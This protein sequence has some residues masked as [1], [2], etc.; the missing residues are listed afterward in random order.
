MHWTEIQRLSFIFSLQQTIFLD[1]VYIK[2]KSNYYTS[3]SSRTDR[4]FSSHPIFSTICLSSTRDCLRWGPREPFLVMS[5]SAAAS[6]ST[7]PHSGVKKKNQPNL[8]SPGLSSIGDIVASRRV[9][10][11]VRSY[12]C[13]NGYRSPPHLGS[14]TYINFAY[15]HLM[16][17]H[18][19]KFCLQTSCG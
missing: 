6:P 12:F 7:S 8:R 1:I 16:D 15:R 19:Y 17:K 14:F 18:I 9:P 4:F 11:P 13:L 10:S 3:S 2:L 5:R